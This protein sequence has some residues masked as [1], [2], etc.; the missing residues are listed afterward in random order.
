MKHLRHIKIALSAFM[1]LPLVSCGGGSIDEDLEIIG[2]FIN[3]NLGSI[4]SFQ[5]DSVKYKIYPNFYEANQNAKNV[6]RINVNNSGLDKLPDDIAKYENLEGLEAAHNKIGEMNAKLTKLSKLSFLD[7]SNNKIEKL[8]E[9]VYNMISLRVLKLHSN[10]ISELPES[11]GYLEGLEELYL[12]DN[13]IDSLPNSFKRLKNLKRLSIASNKLR[14]FPKV[15]TKLK[16]L[17]YLDLSNLYFDKNSEL[18]REVKSKLPNTTI[19]W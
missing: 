11:L 19:I 3:D 12:N 17:E 14:H 18:K 8:P 13:K 7:L 5:P 16:T 10:K 9:S 4:V 2:D 1:F 15:I 6:R